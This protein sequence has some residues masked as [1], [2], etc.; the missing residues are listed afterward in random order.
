MRQ[1]FLFMFLLTFQSSKSNRIHMI[2]HTFPKF[3]ADWRAYAL[4][5]FFAKKN[6]LKLLFSILDFV[7]FFH[8]LHTTQQ[9]SNEYLHRMFR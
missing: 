2:S 6:R 9:L 3:D 8:I 4:V 5:S 7:S 1:F